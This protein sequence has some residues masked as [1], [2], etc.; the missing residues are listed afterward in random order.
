LP[1]RNGELDLP[2]YFES[3]SRF[4][5]AIVALDDGSTD[6][7]RE[8]LDANPL[9]KIV[10]DNPR[11]EDYVGWDDSDNRNRLL[12]AAAQLDPEWILSLDVD[13]R[14]AADDATAL[15]DF[16]ESDAL[17]GCAYGFQIFRMREDLEHYDRE[18][19]WVY[20]LFAL[21]NGQR[22]PDLR[23]HFVPIPTGI[24]RSLWLQTTIRIQH[25]ASLTEERRQVRF[26]KYRQAD[27]NNEF[28]HSYRDLITAGDDIALWQPR[29][30]GTPILAVDQD[31]VA[32]ATEDAE[33]PSL[34][35][36]R[37][38]P[39]ISA[40]VISRDDGERI[41][42]SVASVAGQICAWP[43]EVIVVT[44]GSGSAGAIVRERF[45]D[46]TVI[47]LPGPALPG[48]A[49]NA[50]LRRA[51]GEYIT[52]PGSHV[53]LPPGSLEARLRAHDL[54]Y[55]MVTGTT[56]NGTRSRAGWA[57]YFLDHSAVLPGLP[58]IELKGAPAHCSYRR[59]ALMS[60]GGFPENLRAGEDTVVN[61]EL[62][63]RGHLAYRA[64]DVQFVHHSRCR[65]PWQLLRHHFVRGRGF[66]RI[67]RDRDGIHSRQLVGQRGRQLLRQQTVRRIR[68][69]KSNVRTGGD[70]VLNAE[71]RKAYPLI[72]AGAFAACA[73]T[74]YELL[75]G[76]PGPPIRSS[77]QVV[78]PLVE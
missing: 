24:P 39:A 2:G 66:G 60:V 21:E 47:E 10:L 25:L 8:L 34:D 16:L 74:F 38:R 23:L 1:V 9:V 75:R 43:F 32:V 4:A 17:S 14:I 71:F 51:R 68:N 59:S 54:G 69:T 67:L 48:A 18:G 49:R 56:L 20:R 7:S 11:R 73:G 52:F 29:Q 28:Q 19:L 78:G 26:D 42:R 3:V 6:R 77:E 40:I 44:S 45:P 57:S 33:H 5:D 62:A 58:S 50:G 36:I 64:A 70:T 31:E 12:A 30:P 55:S 37:D 41:L 65:T 27:P 53:E 22:F 61:Q 46:V 76:T 63:R 72:V 35:E 15:R 13:E